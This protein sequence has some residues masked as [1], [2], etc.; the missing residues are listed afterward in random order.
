MIIY[1]LSVSEILFFLPL[2]GQALLPD[3]CPE[4]IGQEQPKDFEDKRI[5]SQIKLC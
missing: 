3:L 2:L 1:R 5:H 4:L